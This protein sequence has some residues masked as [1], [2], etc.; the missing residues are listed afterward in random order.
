MVYNTY[1]TNHSQSL[2]KLHSL[3]QSNRNFKNFLEETCKLP[4]C[5]GLALNSFLIKP[6]QRICKYPLL[7][8][9]CLV[10]RSRVKTTKIFYTNMANN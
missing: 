8:K 9:V 2:L 6:V 7:L 10:F 3:L 4:V 5:R 1:C